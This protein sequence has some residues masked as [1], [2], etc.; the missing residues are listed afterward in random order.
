MID[1]VNVSGCTSLILAIS[2]GHQSTVELLLTHGA[3]IEQANVDGFTPLIYASSIGHQSIVELLLNRGA[4]IE[5]GCRGD[6]PLI[7]ASSS[8]HQSIVQLLLNRGANIDQV[9]YRGNTPLIYASSN[10]HHS[11]VELLLNRGAKIDQVDVDGNAPLDYARSGGHQGIVALVENHTLTLLRRDPVDF[12]TKLFEDDGR[13]ID[14]K[15]TE[16]IPLIDHANHA[17]IFYTLLGVVG[18]MK[19][20]KESDHRKYIKEALTKTAKTT[21]DS[22]S[23]ATFKLILKKAKQDGWVDDYTALVLD[24]DAEVVHTS[25]A[26]FVKDIRLDI[27]NVKKRLD[28]VE[29]R[30]EGLDASLNK[31]RLAFRQHLRNKAICECMGAVFNAISFG[32]GGSV[33]SAAMNSM[34]S[35]IVDFGD[36]VHIQSVV[37]NMGDPTVK[38]AFDLGLRYAENDS[39]ARFA[40]S[41]SSHPVYVIAVT[42]QIV[43]AE[44]ALSATLREN[45][46]SALRQD[47]GRKGIPAT[48]ES[49]A[50]T[51]ADRV[52]RLAGELGVEFDSNLNIKQ[53]IECLEM[54]VHD[55]ERGGGIPHRVLSLEAELKLI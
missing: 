40:A 30:I 54:L 35:N 43:T 44:A 31:M 12:Y 8:G 46:A 37:E 36:I 49:G 14:D 24:R 32:I 21:S 29:Q 42:A 27:Q 22:D 13:N 51:L 10:G 19:S 33:L 50:S 1:Q 52:K 23:I 16:L 28:V 34:F 9:G 26:Q 15:I 47:A 7:Y 4:N 3:N 39:E 18:R 48:S 41:L 55:E 5:Q 11:I 6:T 17:R 45:P 38:D 20:I 53:K 2:I 25:N